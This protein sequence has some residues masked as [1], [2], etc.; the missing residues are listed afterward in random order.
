ML[1]LKWVREN[2]DAVRKDLK[3]RRMDAEL[4]ETLLSADLE[5]RRLKQEVDNLR[6]ERNRLTE[7]VRTLKKAGSNAD[8]ELKKAANIPDM[9]KT[10]EESADRELQRVKY[11]MMRLPNIL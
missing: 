8:A 11:S 9:I 3:R 4:L 7:Q 5:Y 10:T 6:A 2:P 1:D